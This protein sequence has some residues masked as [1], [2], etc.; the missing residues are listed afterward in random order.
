VAKTEFL[1]KIDMTR[2]RILLPAMLALATLLLS[3]VSLQAKQSSASEKL[4]SVAERFVLKWYEFDPV[5]ATGMGDHTYDNRYP[6]FSQKSF[7]RYAGA[8]RGL[9]GELSGVNQA[10]LNSDQKLDYLTLQSLL[11]TQ[12]FY[13][14]Q[15]LIMQD[16]PKLFSSKASE[17][18]YRI[19]LSQSLSD[20]VKLE[21][22]I[23]RLDDL[24]R[25]LQ[26]AQR[27]LKEPPQI[28]NL[29]AEEEA[30]NTSS[31][32]KEITDHYGNKFPDRREELQNKVSAAVNALEDFSDFLDT[33]E[34]KEGQPFAVGKELFDKLLKQQYFL[35]YGSDSLLKI[36]E[37]LF[38]QYARTYDS[39]SA[40]V[41][42]L[43]T[44]EDFAY[45]IPKSFGRADVMDY[46][47]WEINQTKEWVTTHDFASIPNYIA[48]C[49]PVETPAFMD[50]VVGGIAYQPAGPFEK[51]QSGRFYVRPLPDSLS[52]ANR[53][54]YFRYCTRR[55][56]KSAVVHEA[57]PGR[58]L[59]IEMA[60]HNPSLIRQ[61]QRDDMMVEG[62]SLYCEEEMYRQRF[63]GDDL[64]T[65][66]SILSSLRF[67][68]ARI[69]VDVKLQTGQFTYQQAVDWMVANLD[70]EV[71]YIEK[72][73]NLYSLAP[74]EPSSYL[75]G[76]EYLLMSR[77]IY[78]TK[79]GPKY[80]LRK[81]N[82]FILGQ[83]AVSPVLIYKQL[84]GR[85]F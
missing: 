4:Q 84:T 46:F 77:E 22:I 69:V 28:W 9:R 56:F 11:E 50:K 67:R 83:G 40:I 55:G 68:A 2:I 73:V 20:T 76:R 63:Y 66:L 17:G 45:F 15:T 10:E 52:D 3:A 33:L 37:A 23:E 82:D 75:L 61:M 85:I 62:W 39:V 18:I 21:A 29:L 48:D 51:V 34:T 78:K 53:S 49:T 13:L 8:L 27:L 47:Q 41:D 43:P 30:D 32:L 59:E 42:T 60:N 38:A 70:A 26:S 58:H 25:F 54:A 71:D 80:T 57:Y 36:G 81:F 74:G 16:N 64:R 1:E 31:F 79:L 65:Y 5:Y 24:P 12:L 44:P 35:D 14:G 72:E 19:I 6:D 7:G